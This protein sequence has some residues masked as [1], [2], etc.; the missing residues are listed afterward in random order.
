MKH[1][2]PRYLGRIS[3]HV[4]IIDATRANLTC[5]NNKL[6]LRHSD[7]VGQKDATAEDPGKLMLVSFVALT[8]AYQCLEPRPYDLWAGCHSVA[9][10]YE[11]MRCAPGGHAVQDVAGMNM[12]LATFAES[13]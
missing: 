8:A 7:D 6:N 9:K 4:R 10:T 12:R 2:Q 5:S 13:I 3:R 1:P 11:L